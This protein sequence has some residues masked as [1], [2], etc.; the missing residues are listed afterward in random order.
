[1]VRIYHLIVDYYSILLPSI[2]NTPNYF[3]KITNPHL[4]SC[5]IFSYILKF[6]LLG[7][8]IGRRDFLRLTFYVF[9][10]TLAVECFAG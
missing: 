5:P 3:P 4:S 2:K 8:L 7:S 10:S 6:N 1:M 9:A